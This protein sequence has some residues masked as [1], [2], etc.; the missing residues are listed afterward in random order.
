MLNNI[1]IPTHVKANH[2]TKAT[3]KNGIGWVSPVSKS[4]LKISMIWTTSN[5]DVS[6][7]IADR[8][9]VH[10]SYVRWKF[11]T[12]KKWWTFILKSN[13]TYPT[14]S[15][16]LE[17]GPTLVASLFFLI[18][19]FQTHFFRY[20]S[21]LSRITFECINYLRRMRLNILSP[22]PLCGSHVCWL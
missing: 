3:F 17:T 5:F 7:W 19:D 15:A 20:I 21:M 1:W 18:V 14:G 12:T 10:D 13:F 6:P 8:K 9:L 4:S 11:R 2:G 22:V 16:F